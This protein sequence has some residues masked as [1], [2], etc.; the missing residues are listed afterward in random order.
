[1]EIIHMKNIRSIQF[2][3][4]F[5]LTGVFAICGCNS[6]QTTDSN[7]TRFSTT[8][9]FSICLGAPKKSASDEKTFTCVTNADS[10]VVSFQSTIYCTCEYRPDATINK[11][12]PDTL[13]I[14][15]TP[16]GSLRSKCVCIKEISVVIKPAISDSVHTLLFHGKV[17]VR[18]VEH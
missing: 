8:T 7:I 9:S 15:L 11:E 14:T 6:Q 16:V 4:T 5:F 17:F 13:R 12:S 3:C 10:S 1:M 18:S 2:Y